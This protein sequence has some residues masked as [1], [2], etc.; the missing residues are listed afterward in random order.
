MCIY[1]EIDSGVPAF[2]AEKTLDKLLASVLTQS[3]SDQVAIVIANDYP[4]DNGKYSFVKD[5]YPSLDINWEMK[6]LR[7]ML[8]LLN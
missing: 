3:M 1:E 4:G 8:K 7:K 2:K 6:L 5:L